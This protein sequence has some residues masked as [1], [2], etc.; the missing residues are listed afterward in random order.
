MLKLTRAALSKFNIR[1]HK[2][3]SNS[4]DVLDSFEKS[5]HADELQV[6]DASRSPTPRVLGVIWHVE[7]DTFRIHFTTPTQ[8]LTKRGLLSIINSIYEPLGL[9]TLVTL[10]GR[11]ALRE[12]TSK[13]YLKKLKSDENKNF[14][15]IANWDEDL[16]SQTQS[17]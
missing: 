10:R 17:V 4:K 3:L 14:I 9:V 6:E 8:T 16:P 5:E 12:A 7:D 2:L 13:E 11:Q 1:L 15:A